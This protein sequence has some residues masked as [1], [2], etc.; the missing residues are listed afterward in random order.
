MDVSLESKSLPSVGYSRKSYLQTTSQ[1]LSRD[2][3]VHLNERRSFALSSVGPGGLQ[4]EFGDLDI[5]YLKQNISKSRSKISGSFRRTPRHCAKWLRNSPGLIADRML[6]P[7]T[8]FLSIVLILFGMLASDN[9]SRECNVPR[10]ET[11]FARSAMFSEA[12]GEED[13][14]YNSGNS[15]L[16]MGKEVQYLNILC[17]THHQL[18]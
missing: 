18:P 9:P 14:L 16:A 6:F 13:E 10:E 8:D 11:D 12:L 7:F 1:R 5:K 4:G 15:H 3:L 2:K 17:R